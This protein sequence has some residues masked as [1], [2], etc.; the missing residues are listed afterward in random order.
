M[1]RSSRTCLQEGTRNRPLLR[2]RRSA[3]AP[4]RLHEG[5]RRLGASGVTYSAAEETQRVV[6]QNRL[7]LGVVE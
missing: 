6:A 4:A 3:Q 5:L 2:A 7:A 1:G